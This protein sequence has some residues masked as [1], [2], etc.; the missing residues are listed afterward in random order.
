MLQ[1]C[2]DKHLPKPPEYSNPVV[3][4]IFMAQNIARTHPKMFCKKVL[5][6]LENRFEGGFYYDMNGYGIK[7]VEGVD[8]LHDCIEDLQHREPMMPLEWNRDL[9]AAAKDH[10]K[11]IGKHGLLGH[12]SSSGLGVY[13]RILMNNDNQA[14]GMWAENITY[15]SMHPV[16]IVALMLIDDG[17]SKRT[18]RENAL[19]PIHQIA[20]V[21]FG[22]HVFKYFVTVIVY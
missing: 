15:E 16:E 12:E 19:D 4:D 22:G 3:Q 17:D 10:A 5:S 8:A 11:D 7:V 9:T 1:F 20:G 18:Q 21:S 13:D 2:E 14:V 6:K